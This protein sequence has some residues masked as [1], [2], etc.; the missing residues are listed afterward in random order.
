MLQKLYER[1]KYIN[2]LI[3]IYYIIAYLTIEFLNTKITED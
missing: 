1:I 3:L 2:V